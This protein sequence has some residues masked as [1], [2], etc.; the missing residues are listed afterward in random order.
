VIR[1]DPVPEEGKAAL[2]HAME[3]ARQAGEDAPQEA[4]TEAPAAVED[5][6]NAE[7]FQAVQTFSHKK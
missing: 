2:H 6:L 4:G 7:L 1:L 3:Q 5:D